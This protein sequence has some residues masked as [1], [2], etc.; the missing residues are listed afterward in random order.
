MIYNS[1]G[2][3][4]VYSVVSHEWLLSSDES[5][6]RNNIKETTTKTKRKSNVKHVVIKHKHQIVFRSKLMN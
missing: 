1:K 6:R 4:V 3:S 5:N 2:L